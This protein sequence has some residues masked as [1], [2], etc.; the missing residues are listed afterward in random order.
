MFFC[1]FTL[2]IYFRVFSF[3]L[4]SFLFLS[5][6]LYECL[7]HVCVCLV[8]VCLSV[9]AT[10]GACW[11]WCW[12]FCISHMLCKMHYTDTYLLFCFSLL[13]FSFYETDM[14]LSCLRRVLSAFSMQE[15]SIGYC[16]SLNFVCAMFLLFMEEEQAFWALTA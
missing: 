9:F 7:F 1:L 15:S 10:M 16:Q 8:Y 11:C 2:Y 13:F 6:Y 3:L 5:L 4:S 12:C 14:G